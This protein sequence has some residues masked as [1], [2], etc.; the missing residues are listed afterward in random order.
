[1]MYPTSPGLSWRI[2][3]SNSFSASFI[4]CLIL[5]HT[6]FPH[7]STSLDIFFCFFLSYTFAQFFCKHHELHI[8]FLSLG[9]LSPSKRHPLSDNCHTKFIRFAYCISPWE[10]SGYLAT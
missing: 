2:S 1:M 6:Q 4:P 10:L 3:V 7:D 5:T 8:T 9:V